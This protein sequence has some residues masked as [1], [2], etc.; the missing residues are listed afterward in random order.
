MVE[1]IISKCHVCQ[2][3]KKSHTKYGKLPEKEAETEPW[4]KLCVDL[5]GPYTMK[6]RKNK[7]KKE[8]EPVLWCVTMIDPATGW[9]EMKELPDKHA[10][11]VADIVE[12]TWL[13]R[14]PWPTEIT[15]DKGT[16][17]MAEFATMITKD[18]GMKKRGASVRN[19]QANAI[20]E[21]IHQTIGNII[22]TFTVHQR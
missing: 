20:L 18:Y 15:Y 21:R 7:K 9:F 19:P 10:I 12:Q 13:T 14:Y 5:I 17:F 3:C 4:N 8:Q 22:R 2:K 1:D 16:E 6:K 11:T